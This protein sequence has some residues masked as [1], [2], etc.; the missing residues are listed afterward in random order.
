MMNVKKLRLCS[1]WYSV[2]LKIATIVIEDQEY[3]T[4]PVCFNKT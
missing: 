4:I 2:P 3:I 1:M